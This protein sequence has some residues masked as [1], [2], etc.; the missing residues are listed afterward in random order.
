MQ[1]MRHFVNYTTKRERQNILLRFARRKNQLRTPKQRDRFPAGFS[2][3]PPSGVGHLGRSILMYLCD[4]Y[5]SP[6]EY[7]FFPLVSLVSD[8]GASDL[9]LR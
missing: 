1:I 3:A 8:M 4:S 5:I 6:G 2:G 9:P 7:G